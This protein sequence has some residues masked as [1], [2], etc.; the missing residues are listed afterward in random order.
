MMGADPSGIF[1]SQV[2]YRTPVKADKKAKI[3][4][5]SPDYVPGAEYHLDG[6]ANS[7]GTRFPDPWTVMVGVALVDVLTADMGNFTV[8]P[9][10][11]TSRDWSRYPEEKVART[12]PDLGRTEHLCLPAGGAVFVHVLLAHRGGKN[13]KGQNA[14]A[15]VEDAS[16]ASASADYGLRRVG[17]VYAATHI[18]Q[19]TREMVFIRV[20]AD[21]VDYLAPERAESVLRDPWHEFRSMCDEH[22]AQTVEN[23]R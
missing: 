15:D 17:D 5:P 6:S 19:D 20:Q 12:L 23:A 4:V 1:Y 21:G 3:K 9:G 8:F 14:A 10:S 2:A 11:H 18:P 7:S 22:D 13:V 16:G